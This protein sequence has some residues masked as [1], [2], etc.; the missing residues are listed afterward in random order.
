MLDIK[1]FAFLIQFI[2]R[3]MRQI[4]QVKFY[5]DIK[6][7]LGF[8]YKVLFNKQYFYSKLLID[9][10][11]V[12][13]GS[14]FV[15]V[16]YQSRFAWAHEVVWGCE[17]WQ[18]TQGQ[19]AGRP[20]RTPG[21]AGTW[22]LGE[23]THFIILTHSHCVTVSPTQSGAHWSRVT[24]TSPN[25]WLSPAHPPG[26]ADH[27]LITRVFDASDPGF[28]MSTHRQLVFKWVTQTTAFNWTGI[29]RTWMFKEHSRMQ[30]GHSETKDIQTITMLG[31]LK[32]VTP[33]S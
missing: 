23:E 31:S 11:G 25:S 32:W 10:L 16:R 24:S 17:N 13:T 20:P 33:G 2:E 3:R 29:T 6:I 26:T 18:R 8:Y 4:D 14:K 30:T 5:S 15:Y 1:F 21:T 19:W 22:R 9:R 12:R 27:S 7:F 28:P